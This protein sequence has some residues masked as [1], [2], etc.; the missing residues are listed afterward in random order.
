MEDLEVGTGVLLFVLLLAVFF[1]VIIFCFFICYTFV[2]KKNQC[3]LQKGMPLVRRRNTK[4]RQ[5]RSGGLPRLPP[6]LD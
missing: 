1:V 2:W 3:D 5:F 6:D 4:S